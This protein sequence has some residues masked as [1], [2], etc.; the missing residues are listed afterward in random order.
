[1]S[2]NYPK[3]LQ[4]NTQHFITIKKED[5]QRATDK[6]ANGAREA[7]FE[8]GDY[9]GIMQAHPLSWVKAN[10]VWIIDK[11]F[12]CEVAQFFTKKRKINRNKWGAQNSSHNYWCEII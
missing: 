8:A 1:M 11:E 3:Q 6:I 10:K 9:S 12:G 7:F 5:L 4:R 2:F